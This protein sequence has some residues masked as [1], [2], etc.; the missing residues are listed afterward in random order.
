MLEASP[1]GA[2][3]VDF[4]AMDAVENTAGD[5][6]AL[7]E[8]SGDEDDEDDEEDEDESAMGSDAEDDEEDD[9]DEEELPTQPAPKAKGA[10]QLKGVKGGASLDDPALSFGLATGSTDGRRSHKASLKKAAKHN[11]RAGRSMDAD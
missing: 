9:E 11:R 1:S 10:K 8:G 2:A 7:M 5:E 3:A 4:V 6:T